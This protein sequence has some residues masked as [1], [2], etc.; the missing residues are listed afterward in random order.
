MSHQHSS[1][2]T[3][4][5]PTS[6]NRCTWQYCGSACVSAAGHCVL[7]RRYLVALGITS[8]AQWSVRKGSIVQ[9]YLQDDLKKA[10]TIPYDW[11]FMIESDDDASAKA[12]SE[13]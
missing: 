3:K 9:A 4:L 5:Q 2:L 13:K 1:K 10:P 8:L 12:L 11:S 6:F 7:L